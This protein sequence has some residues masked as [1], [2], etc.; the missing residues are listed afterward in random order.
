MEE[1]QEKLIVVITGLLSRLY[2]S[3]RLLSDACLSHP[4]VVTPRAL[5]KKQPYNSLLRKIEKSF[6]QLKISKSTSDKK[7][8]DDLVRDSKST[9]SQLH[10]IYATMADICKWQS[11]V[12]SLLNQDLGC[13][14]LGDT[15]LTLQHDS[16]GE[17]VIANSLDLL[18]LYLKSLLF[19]CKWN[20]LL[21]RVCS[22]Y[23]ICWRLA[24]N[25]DIDGDWPRVSKLLSVTETQALAVDATADDLKHAIPGLFEHILA[26]NELPDSNALIAP[27]SIL[28]QVIGASSSQSSSPFHETADVNPADSPHCLVFPTK[29]S[30]HR[31]IARYSNRMQGWLVFGAWYLTIPEFQMNH[32]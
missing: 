21:K 17:E 10:P 19:I 29:Q 5:D 24:H 3:T 12:R 2:H 13:V 31:C 30:R 11:R 4:R 25:D 22:V 20:A 1:R 15:S 18:T 6:P 9:L 32:L 26:L 14:I 8:Y 23:A 27:S 28:A 7:G 16:L